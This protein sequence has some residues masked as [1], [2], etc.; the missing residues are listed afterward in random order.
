MKKVNNLTIEQQKKLIDFSINNFNLIDNPEPEIITYFLK[1]TNYDITNFIIIDNP[2][3]IK[4][5]CLNK[6]TDN[7]IIDVILGRSLSID[8]KI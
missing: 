1:I 4:D 6:L 5:I 7:E 3:I 2:E 8:K